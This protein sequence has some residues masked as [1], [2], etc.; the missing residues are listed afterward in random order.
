[1]LF[2][3]AMKTPDNTTM[4]AVWDPRTRTYH[5]EETWEHHV[6]LQEELKHEQDVLQKIHRRQLESSK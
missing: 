4:T 2:A 5:L 1:M 3:R 6:I